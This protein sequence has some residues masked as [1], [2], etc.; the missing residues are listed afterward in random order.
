MPQYFYTN[1]PVVPARRGGDLTIGVSV[2]ASVVANDWRSV[3]K[4]WPVGSAQPG[5][6]S[7]TAAEPIITGPQSYAHPDGVTTN[8][9]YVTLSAAQTQAMSAG[10][11]LLEIDFSVGDVRKKQREL[12]VI[13]LAETMLGG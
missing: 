2:P 1:P 3:V 5:P 10:R 7:P 9:Y 12:V 6:S 4:A 8:A 13:D 11:Y